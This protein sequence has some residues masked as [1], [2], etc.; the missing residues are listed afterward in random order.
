MDSVNLDSHNGTEESMYLN[1]LLVGSMK[2][3]LAKCVSYNSVP[4]LLL[5]IHQS[6]AYIVIKTPLQYLGIP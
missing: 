1:W 5:W 6:L 2:C 3:L 4:T